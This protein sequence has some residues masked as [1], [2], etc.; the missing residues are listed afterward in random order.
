MQ[1]QLLE[2]RENF[3]RWR[4]EFG[5]NEKK[6][7]FW[8]FSDETKADVSLSLAAILSSGYQALELRESTWRCKG[9][10]CAVV[11]ERNRERKR[12]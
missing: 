6:R 11:L 3:R 1:R 5:N 7:Q 12:R 8:V 10:V 4:L 9:L 2:A